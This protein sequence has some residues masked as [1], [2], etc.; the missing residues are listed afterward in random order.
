M[1]SEERIKEIYN[2]TFTEVH[3]SDELKGLVENMAENKNRIW[4]NALKKVRL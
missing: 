2:S 4:K 3:A 1:S